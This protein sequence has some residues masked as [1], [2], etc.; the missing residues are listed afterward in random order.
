MVQ[1][2][3][4][5]IP[6]TIEG[7]GTFGEGFDLGPGGGPPPGGRQPSLGGELT[8]PPLKYKFDLGAELSALANLPRILLVSVLDFSGTMRI[9]GRFAS[10]DSSRSEEHTS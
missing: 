2:G 10:A 7:P 5:R 1:G 3:G 9:R 6:P 8:P 4:G